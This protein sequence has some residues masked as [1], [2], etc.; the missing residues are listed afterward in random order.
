VAVAV[1]I[2]RAAL[3]PAPNLTYFERGS[4]KFMQ[5]G[6]R[7][8][9]TDGSGT[10]SPVAIM[11][12]LKLPSLHYMLRTHRSLDGC[13]C[14]MRERPMF[15]GGFRHHWRPGAA[16][17]WPGRGCP[18]PSARAVQPFGE[19]L[20]QICCRC[21]KDLLKLQFLIEV[22][23]KTTGPCLGGIVQL[24]CHKSVL[25]EQLRF[26]RCRAEALGGTDVA[27]SVRFC[28]GGAARLLGSQAT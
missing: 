3:T 25:S 15:L 11:L 22:G 9:P 2:A 21:S 28:S 4:A 5:P 12:I 8:W 14:W 6:V 23:A 26:R 7:V 1:V 10:A 24:P 17:R 18:L 20:L 13:H 19:F 16:I 27:E